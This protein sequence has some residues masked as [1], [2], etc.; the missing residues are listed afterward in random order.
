MWI[1]VG[2]PVFSSYPHWNN[3]FT[4]PELAEGNFQVVHNASQ[5]RFRMILKKNVEYTA[6]PQ[7]FHRL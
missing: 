6:N 4:T 1:S 7:S 5:A 3:L 2:N